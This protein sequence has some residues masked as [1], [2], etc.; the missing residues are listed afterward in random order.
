MAADEGA[1]SEARRTITNRSTGE[2][3][4]STQTRK[5]W[6]SIEI[7]DI[8]QVASWTFRRKGVKLYGQDLILCKGFL[9]VLLGLKIYISTSRNRKRLH[10][11]SCQ[12]DATWF[13]SLKVT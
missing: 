11:S 12:V 6:S 4:H 5:A 10:T 8:W 2:D 3:I 13:Q 1:T 7:F 9:L